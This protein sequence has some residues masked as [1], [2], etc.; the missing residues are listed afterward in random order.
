MERRHD[1]LVMMYVLSSRDTEGMTG[2]DVMRSWIV[3]VSV[4]V[5]CKRMNV[6]KRP[7]YE[8]VRRSLC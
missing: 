4:G 8:G 6:W 5:V 1:D 3:T 7:A 2:R